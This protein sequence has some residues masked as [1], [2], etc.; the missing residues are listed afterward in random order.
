MLLK[1]MLFEMV[2]FM[3]NFKF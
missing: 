2:F 3:T 1:I